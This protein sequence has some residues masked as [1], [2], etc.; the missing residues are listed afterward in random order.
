MRI[1]RRG[2]KGLR[3]PSSHPVRETVL[4]QLERG[5]H[6]RGCRMETAQQVCVWCV[7]VCV[8]CSVAHERLPELPIISHEK[9]HTGAAAR[10]KGGSKRP[11]SRL[12][13]RA[14]S[15]ASPRDEA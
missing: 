12:E 14:E 1:A 3:S 11:A 6:P 7:W 2:L 5:E 9:P 13:R 4:G 10:E 15:L 8:S